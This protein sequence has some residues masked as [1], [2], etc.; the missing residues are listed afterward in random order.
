MKKLRL[1]L[2][3]AAVLALAL[4]ATAQDHVAPGDSDKKSD[5]KMTKTAS[6]LQ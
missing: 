4:P 6:G 3:P 5:T 2:A 1:L